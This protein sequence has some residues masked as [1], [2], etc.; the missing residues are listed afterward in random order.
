MMVFQVGERFLVSH[1][2]GGAAA[3]LGYLGNESLV[4]LAPG[5]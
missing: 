4:R 2:I 3:K 5:K 1:T